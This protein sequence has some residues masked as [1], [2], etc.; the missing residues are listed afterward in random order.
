MCFDRNPI[1]CVIPPHML[2]RLANSDDAQTRG[3]ALKMIKRTQYLRAKRALILDQPRT[4]LHKM[5]SG[6]D[7][8]SAKRVRRTF[9]GGGKEELPGKLVRQEDDP[10]TGDVM[11]DEAHDGGGVTWDFYQQVFSRN[12]IDD[13]GMII[14]QTVHYGKDFMNAF[15]DGDRMSYGDGDGE[16]FDRFTLDLDIIGH[17][18]THGVIQY[19]AGFRYWFQSGALNESFA[20]VLASLIKQWH[21]GQEVGEADWLVGNNVLLGDGFA[22]RSLAAPGTAYVDHPQLGT[23]P[24][25]AHM[26][27][28]QELGAWDDNG[29]VHINSGIPNH[30]FYLVALELG[31]HAWERAGKIWYRALCDHMKLDDTFVKAAQATLRA[32]RDEYGTGSLEQKAVEKAWKGVGVL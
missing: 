26:K 15:W 20:D 24:Q 9:D 25:P 30:A 19:E 21:L 23:D 17:E 8:H 22:L 10:P 28:Y 16:I 32:A 18:L 29:G 1:H 11:I 4:Q 12:S 31:G 6:L 7:P 13:G 3:R 5:L 14:E 2:D 27:D